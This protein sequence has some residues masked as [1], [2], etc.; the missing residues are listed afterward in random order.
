MQ[1]VLSEK[2]TVKPEVVEI[3]QCREFSRDTDRLGFSI[4]RVNNKVLG[5][6]GGRGHWITIRTKD[7]R[8]C[9]YRRIAGSGGKSLKADSIELDYDS[10]ADLGIQSD[11]DGHGFYAVHWEMFPT[12]WPWTLVA[13]WR[14]PDV[15][16]RMAF[17]LGLI[18]VV[19]GFLG[20]VPAVVSLLR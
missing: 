2:K 14:N 19:L 1:K 11:R 15:G 18:G 16:Y 10:R 3:L 13:H 17:K 9:I 8:K 5:K 4:A 7:T 20:L 6:L 12:R